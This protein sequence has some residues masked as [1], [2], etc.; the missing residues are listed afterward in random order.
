[1]ALGRNAIA[2]LVVLWAG[3]AGAGC[4]GPSSL[5]LTLTLAP[6]IPQPSSLAI[7][8]NGQGQ[9]GAPMAVALAPSKHLPGTLVMGPLDPKQPDFRIKVDGLDASGALASQAATRVTLASGVQTQAELTLAAPLDGVP[10][11]IDDCPNL[12]DPDQR[13]V[14]KG[15]GDDLGPPDL[16]VPTDLALVDLARR[17]QTVPPDLARPVCPANHLFCDSF[18]TGDARY[19][20]VD[21]GRNATITVG[22]AGPPY[23]GVYAAHGV[24][25]LNP[26]D[27]GYTEDYATLD[28]TF[29]PQNEVWLRAYVY[30][31]KTAVY[32]MALRLGKGT[33][34]QVVGIDGS[35][36]WVVTQNNGVDDDLKTGA[37]AAIGKWVCI[38]L[39]VQTVANSVQLFVDSTAMPFL[40]GVTA[41]KAQDSQL[42]VGI[43][44]TPGT[45]ALQ[46]L[47]D[48]VAVAPT[49]IGCE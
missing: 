34:E 10:D 19:W 8:L 45:P 13:C 20:T 18:E 38:E 43:A 28:A 5:S 26:I 9:H 36:D 33:A 42:S 32:E 3:A 31:T 27:G 47:V 22:S 44:R 40:T 15:G 14:A 48:D 11:A 6:A 41:V 37:P 21:T 2:G 29:T 7:T 1:M 12:P 17:D 46:I 23:R 30:F 4:G 39:G 49:R 35:G 16:A 24:A 25:Q